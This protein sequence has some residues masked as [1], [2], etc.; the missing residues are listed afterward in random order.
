[1]GQKGSSPKVCYKID[2]SETPLHSHNYDLA[3]LVTIYI[4]LF[5]TI[6]TG[7][8]GDEL[9]WAFQT[10]SGMGGWAAPKQYVWNARMGCAH[11]TW[12][13]PMVGAAA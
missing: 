4:T 11:S 1:M 9:N 7:N 13:S 12:V 6:C 5:I 10:S 3:K 8:L 2:V